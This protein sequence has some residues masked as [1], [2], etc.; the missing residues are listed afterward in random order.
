MTLQ[1]VQ[2]RYSSVGRRV[3][4]ALSVA[5]VYFLAARI[6][7][8]FAFTYKNVSP[9]WPPSGIAVAAL[10]YWKLRPWPG[11][12]L[13]A[14]F[15]NYTT[16]LPVESSLAIALGNTIEG[17]FAAFILLRPGWFLPSLT[18]LMDVVHLIAAAMLA[19]ILA[20]ALGVAGLAIAVRLSLETY[21]MAALTW[22]FG[23]AMGI[24]VAGSALL[25]LIPSK[26]EPSGTPAP[27]VPLPVA[28]IQSAPS[29]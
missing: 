26:A 15:A 13:G 17:C 29:S 7:L 21:P 4:E 14:F 27:N 12:A 11:V 2:N 5:L 19:S 24:V 25:S 1:S 23:D 10:V 3:I 16:G 6:S 8:H 20:A 28:P 9:V 18:R 22:W